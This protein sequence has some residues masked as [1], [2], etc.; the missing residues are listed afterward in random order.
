[1]PPLVRMTMSL[2]DGF[3]V[4]SSGVLQVQLDLT[5]VVAWAGAEISLS[6]S[7]SRDVLVYETLLS[8]LGV[9]LPHLRPG[10]SLSF[11]L[12]IPLPVAPD[13]YRLR[14]GFHPATVSTDRPSIYCER[15]VRVTPPGSGG[16]FHGLVDL[17]PTA[18]A[19]A[20]SPDAALHD[21]NKPPKPAIPD[22]INFGEAPNPL[23]L[24]G[25][26]RAERSP[27]C[28]FRWTG[29]QAMFL[30]RPSGKKI[31]LDLL[32]CRPG[33]SERPVKCSLFASGLSKS[34]D[35]ETLIGHFTTQGNQSVSLACP[36]A[37][38]GHVT[39]F[40]LIVHDTWKPSDHHAGSEDH[41]ILGIALAS[42][43]AA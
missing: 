17:A 4:D 20:P 16:R 30:L 25:F 5:A 41:R 26:F 2:P 32:A 10:D 8:R 18:E 24:T 33:S 36:D 22:M 19:L 35:D 42:V 21:R 12:R 23:L 40:K 6:L 9:R 1:M 39:A 3:A 37:L 43:S 15:T 28:G 7:N 14:C 38:R 29:E 31:R 13:D 27:T 34:P 11:R